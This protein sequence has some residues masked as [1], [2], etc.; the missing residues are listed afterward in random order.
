MTMYVGLHTL[1]MDPCSLEK[2]AYARAASTWLCT[3]CCVPKPDVCH[4]DVSLQEPPMD[5]PINIVQGCGLTLVYRPFL[6][7]LPTDAVSRDLYLGRVFASDGMESEEWVTVRSRRRLIV[8][9]SK[10]AG[11]RKCDQCG[12]DVYFAMG[13]KYLYPE[14]P[15][16]VAIFESSGGGGLIV[17]NELFTA[18]DLSNWP[19]L[20]IETLPVVVEPKDGFGEL[21]NS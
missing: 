8:R 7:K 15:N 10:H 11:V 4:V 14:P 12:R 6:E 18:L 13:E 21:L 16:D 17:A 3:G 19:K 20:D 5:E 1:T 2:S 9:G